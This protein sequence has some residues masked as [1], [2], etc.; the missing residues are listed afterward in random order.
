MNT[1]N[2]VKMT[3][4]HWRMAIHIHKETSPLMVKGCKLWPILGTC[5][6]KHWRSISVPHLMWHRVFVYDGHLRGPVTLTPNAE[7]LALELSL[8]VF[9]TLVLAGWDSNTKPSACGTNALTH[10]ATAAVVFGRR[11]SES[12]ER[13][14]GSASIYGLTPKTIL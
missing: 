13:C 14:R 4:V 10:C 8:P 2:S 11:L 6:H 9:S 1:S 5:G 3:C 7:R 12:T